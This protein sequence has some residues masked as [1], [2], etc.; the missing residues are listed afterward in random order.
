LKNF[1]I[2]FDNN[3]LFTPYAGAGLG[4]SYIDLEFG[5]ATGVDGEPTFQAGQGFFTYQ[6]IGGI[7]TKLNSFSDFLVEYRFLG[8][9]ELEFGPSND[10]FS[11][12][13]S[14]LFFGAMF[15]Y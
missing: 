8:T 1:V 3:S 13:T 15:E 4:L 7:A 6:A 14:T 5:E 2:E 10:A 12:N 9:S 11:Y